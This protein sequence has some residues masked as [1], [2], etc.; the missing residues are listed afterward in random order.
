[1]MPTGKCQR[2]AV[3]ECNV[4]F[5]SLA[6]DEKETKIW[7][8]NVCYIKARELWYDFMHP[9][10]ETPVELTDKSIIH[11]GKHKGK[12]LKDVPAQYLLWCG[13]QTWI[14]QHPPLQRY[15]EKNRSILEEEVAENE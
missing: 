7:L 12:V 6:S 11:F 13:D 3:K 4:S 1:M 2:C 14:K 10:K 15:I 9:E 5:L 8:C